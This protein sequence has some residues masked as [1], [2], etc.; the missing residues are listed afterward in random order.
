M[1]RKTTN[2]FS[3]EM[4]KGA[5]NGTMQ[6]PFGIKATLFSDM[7]GIGTLLA[8]AKTH[9]RFEKGADA[10]FTSAL[11]ARN[12]LTHGFFE[13]HNFKIQ[14]ANGCAEMV[15]DLEILHTE[16]FTAWQVASELSTAMS[17]ALSPHFGTID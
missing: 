1:A 8:D 13:R 11:K 14:S 3:P 4:L 9:I 15:P 7:A 2:K 6:K 16:L 17:S 12:C 10:F 5:H